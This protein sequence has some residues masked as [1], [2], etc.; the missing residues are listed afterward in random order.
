MPGSSHFSRRDFIKSAT[1]AVGGL[2]TVGIGIP[3]VAYLIDPALRESKKEL[4]VRA[5]KLADMP[6]GKPFPFS[7]TSVQVNGWERTASTYGGFVIR[8]SESPNNLVVLSSRCTHLGC[9]VNWHEETAHFICPCHDASF[10]AEG[11]VVDGPPPRPM[12]RFDT[13]RVTED[14][15]LEIFVKAG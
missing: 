15:F 6:I 4:W 5:G 9:N 3:A 8:I 10:D 14:G 12:D 13:F 1:A 2:I 11:N 7:F